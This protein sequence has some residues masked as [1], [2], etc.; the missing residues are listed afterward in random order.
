MRRPPLVNDA[1]TID[2]CGVETGRYAD[3]GIDAGDVGKS[4]LRAYA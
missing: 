2:E 1:I 3:Y 4:P